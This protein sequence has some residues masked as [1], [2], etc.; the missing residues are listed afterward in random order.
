MRLYKVLDNLKSCNGGNHVWTP[1]EWVRV[2]GKLV[3]CQ[4][5]IHLCRDKDLIQWLGP[6]IWAAE[7][8]GDDLIDHD[9]KIVVR[10]ARI[11]TKYENWNESTARLFACDCAERVL[12][13]C[14]DDPRPKVAIETARKFALGLAT[15]K[16][17]EAAR[18]AARA[19][20]W[21]TAWAAAGAA[22]WAWQIEK[23]MV[24]LHG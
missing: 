22:A 24:L 14:G 11:T 20:A 8:R 5:G 7:Y 18:A 6:E 2:E 16:D 10:E 15:K 9:D 12:D 3:P 17:L 13:L 4:R 21:A 19:G 1:G 23:L